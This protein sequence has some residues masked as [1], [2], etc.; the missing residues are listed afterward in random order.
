MTDQPRN[1]GPD[2]AGRD[3]SGRFVPGNSGK[4]RGARNRATQ[5]VE[6][7]LEGQA[8]ALTAT[9]LK[10]ALGGDITA[11][12]ICLD[13]IAPARKDRPVTLD[14]PPIASAADHAPALAAVAAAVADGEI[15]PAE[16]KTLGDVLELHRRAVE[17]ADL[18]Q[19]IAALEERIAK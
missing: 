18:E 3:A 14:L 15:S 6:T 19:R 8:D 1:S 11:L 17:T 4:P 13:R 12:R 16:G 2:T 7:M 9:A 5:A 10:L